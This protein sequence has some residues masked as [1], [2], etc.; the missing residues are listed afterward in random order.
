LEYQTGDARKVFL[1]EGSVLRLFDLD[2]VPLLLVSSRT[3]SGM[4][5]VRYPIG[6]FDVEVRAVATI[7][8]QSLIVRPQLSWRVTDH[9]TLALGGAVVAGASTGFGG[10]F[11]RNDEVFATVKYAF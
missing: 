11:G 5:L 4:A 3:A 9:A 2:G 1:V 7:K 8:P 6:S 10:Y